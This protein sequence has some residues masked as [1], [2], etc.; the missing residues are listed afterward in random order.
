M[1]WE[2]IPYLVV[3]AAATRSDPFRECGIGVGDRLGH[4]FQ[5]HHVVALRVYNRVRVLG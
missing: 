3:E 1:S 4:A 5:D 2:P